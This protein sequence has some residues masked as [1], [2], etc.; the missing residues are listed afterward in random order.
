M[1]Y[2]GQREPLGVPPAGREP[3]VN[4]FTDVWNLCITS[5]A[6]WVEEHREA[7]RPPWVEE[8]REAAR[9]P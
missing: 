2:S 7:A 5:E 3:D 6:P 8:H 9:P 4:F 1:P